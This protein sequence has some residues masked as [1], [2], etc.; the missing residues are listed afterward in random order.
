MDELI[1]EAMS[2]GETINVDT[3]EYRI[4]IRFEE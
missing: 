3:D 1:K 4:E 2:T